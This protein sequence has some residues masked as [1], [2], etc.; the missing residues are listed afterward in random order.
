MKKIITAY[1]WLE[2]EESATPEE[3]KK[4]WKKKALEFHPDR[5]GDQDTFDKIKRSYECLKDPEKKKAYDA[6]LRV[7]K[8]KERLR[9]AK[10]RLFSS[11]A[12][13]F[14]RE[15]ERVKEDQKRREDERKKVRENRKNS[16]HSAYYDEQERLE[17]EW[18]ENY[19][20][21]MG[22][23]QSAGKTSVGV[24]QVLRSAEDILSSLMEDEEVSFGRHDFSKGSGFV[25][26]EPGIKME[27]KVKDV[28]EDLRDSIEQA[29]RLMRIF[30]NITGGV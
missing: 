18:S 13:T 20:S 27:G 14:E 3:I 29:E 1:T 12:G 7:I 26:V 24:E 21:M 5:G 30:N 11:A 15:S 8:I 22:E 28:A 9:S 23:Y 4:A 17:S 25:G 19:N 16:Q 10:D 6:K 2:I